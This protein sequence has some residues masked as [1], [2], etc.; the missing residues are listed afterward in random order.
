MEKYQGYPGSV[1]ASF[2]TPATRTFLINVYNWM[3]M[4]LALTGVVA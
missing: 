3:A 2:S 4:G 1:D